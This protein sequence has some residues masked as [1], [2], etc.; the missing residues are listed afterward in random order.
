M[1]QNT[2]NLPLPKLVDWQLVTYQCNTALCGTVYGNDPD[3]IPS[4]IL[5]ILSY[6]LAEPLAALF[7]ESLASGVLPAT[8][9]MADIVAIF[10]KGS[11]SVPGN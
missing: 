8:W 9:K 10:K 5:R 1:E 4:A 6:E 11:S 2:G 7:R 3:G